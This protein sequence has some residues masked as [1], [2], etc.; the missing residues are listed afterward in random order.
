MP[1]QNSR[2]GA[3]S[4]GIKQFLA[5]VLAGAP[6]RDYRKAATSCNLPDK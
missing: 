2:T 6:H 3:N 5:A 4:P 1:G